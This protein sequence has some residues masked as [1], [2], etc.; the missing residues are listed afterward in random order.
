[1]MLSDRLMLFCV[2]SSHCNSTESVNNIN[3]VLFLQVCLLAAGVCVVLVNCTFWVV[4]YVPTSTVIPG[5]S[6][7]VGKY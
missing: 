7:L 3:Q 1:M 2:L 5:I 6:D 4:C